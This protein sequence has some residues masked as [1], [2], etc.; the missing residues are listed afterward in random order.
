MD[1]S[2][3]HG[4]IAEEGG[5][6]LIIDHHGKESDRN[7]SATKFVYETLVEMGLLKKEKYLDQFVEFVTKCDNKNFTMDETKQVLKNYSKNPYGLSN[8]MKAEDI[9]ELFKQGVDPM[10][11]LSDDYLKSHEYFNP[12]NGGR[13][14]S[15][16][17]L[18]EFMEKQMRSGKVGLDNLEKAG[19]IVDTGADRFGKIL[20][21]T[22]KNPGKDRY[23]PI[24][25]GENQS[26]QLEVFL[27]GYGG[28]L[29]WSPIENNFALY[30]QR[31]MDDK[32][33]PGGFS[34][35][36]NMR[37]NMWMKG[38]DP[39]ELT[40]T[41]EEIFSKL[42][43]KSFKPEARLKKA[44]SVDTASKEIL[45]LIDE[46]KLTEDEIK[47]ITREKGISFKDLVYGVIANRAKIGG[48]YGK[49]KKTLSAADQKNPREIERIVAEVLLEQQ[50]NLNKKQPKAPDQKQ[51]KISNSAKELSGLFL[52]FELSVEAIKKEAGKINVEPSELAIGF[53]ES[54]PELK[55]QYETKSGSIDKN[56]LKEVE[57]LA[58]TVILEDEKKKV[59]EK[60]RI[61]GKNDILRM[62]LRE[63]NVDLF[64]IRRIIS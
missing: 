7:T 31:K 23:F 53:I 17:K 49:K 60:I 8:R 48:E 26:N 38:N 52:T 29:I 59:E 42:S 22:K 63:I 20:I 27:K 9:L 44:L 28:Y 61:E 12:Q 3:K 6:R 25:D 56:N 58:M 41:L 19:F 51:E 47:K 21:D 13:Y 15:L 50:K 39:A 1:T 2:M 36:F 10:E 40:I 4:V 34:Q 30:T 46:N 18:V 32:S 37:G 54:N 24:V 55:S 16:T 45:A 14:E 64:E 62:T 35:G 57:K 33:L 43:G 11:Y 5:K